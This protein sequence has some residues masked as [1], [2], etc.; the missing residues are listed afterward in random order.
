MAIYSVSAAT[1]NPQHGDL[2]FAYESDSSENSHVFNGY[3]K[4]DWKPIQFMWHL[5]NNQ[6]R[7][8]LV[9]NDFVLVIGAGTNIAMNKRAK[10]VLAPVL[11]DDAEYLPI[12]VDGED[13]EHWYLLNILH[14]VENALSEELSTYRIRR[15]GSK[16]GLRR[17]VFVEKNIPD[18]RIFVYPDTYINV[19]VKG[20][21]LEELV[22][23]HK[24]TGLHFTPCATAEAG[25]LP[26]TA[27]G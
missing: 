4:K 2:V 14:R 10:K 19:K 27:A 1:D 11:G 15:D 16:G 21:F 3:S 24:L 12:K 13:S 9:I 5:K 25:P 26:K 6:K 7:Q 17:A 23:K 22:N 18:N 20:E 8:N